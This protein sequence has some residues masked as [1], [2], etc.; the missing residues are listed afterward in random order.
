M[1][2]RKQ[3]R[4]A[5]WHYP[6]WNDIVANTVP[7]VNTMSTTILEPLE[8]SP[9]QQILL[10]TAHRHGD[11]ATERLESEKDHAFIFIP[12]PIFKYPINLSI[13]MASGI[14]VKGK[15]FSMISRRGNTGVLVVDLQTPSNLEYFLWSKP[16][17]QSLGDDCGIIIVLWVKY[18]CP[19]SQHGLL[20]FS[21]FSGQ[22]WKLGL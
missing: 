8:F 1:A 4:E 16:H 14:V 15:L 21:E 9:T 6:E 20:T 12:V 3:C 19:P 13:L 5:T 10:N 7:L 22:I 2:D 18:T 17:Q 11:I